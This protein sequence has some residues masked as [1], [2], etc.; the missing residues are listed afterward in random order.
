MVH[1]D[2]HSELV[3]NGVEDSSP[4]KGPFAWKASHKGAGSDSSDEEKEGTNKS[5]D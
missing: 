4:E 5:S 1:S 2:F 3:T